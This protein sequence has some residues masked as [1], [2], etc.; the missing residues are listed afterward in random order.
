MSPWWRWQRF[1]TARDSRHRNWFCEI[2]DTHRGNGSATYVLDFIAFDKV[3]GHGFWRS[4]ADTWKA[5]AVGCWVHPGWSM[6]SLIIVWKVKGKSGRGI[7][8]MTEPSLLR[9]VKLHTLPD[10]KC[11]QP[12]WVVQPRVYCTL[13]SSLSH[14][15]R[16]IVATSLEWSITCSMANEGTMV[17]PP[18]SNWI[19]Y[20]GS[21][22]LHVDGLLGAGMASTYLLVRLVLLGTVTAV[23]MG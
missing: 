5:E 13:L 12:W 11:S 17:V 14:E 8:F 23:P 6:L 22:S 20:V 4:E 9:K 16:E 7:V 1:E 15:G 18:M 19:V 10:P 2:T 21:S 3:R